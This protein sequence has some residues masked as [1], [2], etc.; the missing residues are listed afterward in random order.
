MSFSLRFAIGSAF[1]FALI[2]ISSV[3]GAASDSRTVRVYVDGQEQVVST[4]ASTVGEVLDRMDVKTSEDDFI[5]PPADTN[6]DQSGFHVNVFRARPVLVVD[7]SN[8][9]RVYTAHQSP[10]LIAEA[11]GLTVY[12]EDLFTLE[13]TQDFIDEEF[14]GQKL[15]IDRATPVNLFFDGEIVNIR[16]HLKTVEDL[17]KEQGLVIGKEDTLNVKESDSLVT[18]MDI[19]LTRVGRKLVTINESVPFEKQVI[20]DSNQAVDWE[21]VEQV[22]VDGL[23]VNTYEIVEHNGVEVSRTQIQSVIKTKPTTEIKKRGNKPSFSGSFGQALARLRACESG[24]NYANKR[25]PSFRGAYQF[26]FT[27]WNGYG[28]YFDPADAPASVQDQ[29]AFNLYKRRGWQP[30]PSCGASLPDIYR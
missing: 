20:Y 3:P 6:I 9:Y 14:V 12:D 22:G 2:S 25:N 10:K 4:Q 19:I 27:T 16:T 13:A 8:E 18:N 29:A 24:G 28:G 15:I 30:W 7:G 1:V 17:L 23:K 5:E 26:G 11:A 21:Q